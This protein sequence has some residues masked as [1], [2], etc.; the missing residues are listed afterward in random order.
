MAERY[1]LVITR[2]FQAMTKQPHPKRAAIVRVAILALIM[3]LIGGKWYLYVAH[4]DS[5]YDDFGAGINS[6]MPAPIKRMGC[7]MLEKRF[8]DIPIPPKGCNVAG[9]WA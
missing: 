2:S 9:R 8:G 4:A 5:P 6:I 3:M 1:R 7:R